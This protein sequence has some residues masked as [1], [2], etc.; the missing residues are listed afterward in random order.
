MLPAV[1][2]LSRSGSKGECQ[3]PIGL[4]RRLRLWLVQ[5]LRLMRCCVGFAAEAAPDLWPSAVVH[6]LFHCIYRVGFQKP[7]QS[8][9][10]PWK[11][12]SLSLC[13]YSE[14]HSPSSLPAQVALNNT[15][16][17]LPTTT[18]F[19]WESCLHGG[20]DG[21][22]PRRREW[23]PMPVFLP[24]KFYGQTSLAGYCPWGCKESD[25]I[26]WL[27]LWLSC[28]HGVI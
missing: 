25:R 10:F 5:T 16:I 17:V 7:R 3:D 4:T 11:T 9:E 21:K 23:Q 6:C 2:V 15:F 20:S 8:Q 22:I 26:E 27:T 28:L 12:D 18:T 24:G 14:W 13:Q 1:T 19:G